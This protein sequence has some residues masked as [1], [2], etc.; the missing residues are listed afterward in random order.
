[1]LMLSHLRFYCR[2]AKQGH[3]LRSHLQKVLRA[4]R[5]MVAFT[6][7]SIP[8]APLPSLFRVSLIWYNII[9]MNEAQ[10]AISCVKGPG[11]QAGENPV[12]RILFFHLCWLLALPVVPIFVFDGNDRPS[13]KRGVKV[14]TRAH[15]L[16]ERLQS[17]IEA[18]GFHWYTVAFL[19]SL[20]F[21]VFS[22]I[23][24]F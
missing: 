6:L 22:L 9:W 4:A 8:G 3:L 18:F 17:F 21:L 13:I 12:L 19:Y 1:M 16:T 14:K 7:G 23:F 15:W 5:R 20:R 2:L 24:I 11:T 10:M